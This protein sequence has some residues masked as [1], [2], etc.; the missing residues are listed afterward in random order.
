MGAACGRLM[1]FRHQNNQSASAAN[2]AAPRRDASERATMSDI[3]DSTC[4]ASA[5]EAA[6]EQ[7]APAAELSTPA[8]PFENFSVAEPENA[9]PRATLETLPEAIAAAC[10]RG[11]DVPHARAVPGPALSAGRPRHHGAV[12]YRQRQD[13][14]L[15]A[16]P[17]AASGSRAACR[18][19]PRSWC[20]PASW[21]C[22]WSTRRAP[23]SKAR[24]SVPWPSMAAWATK[25]RWTPCVTGPS[26][27]WARPA[28][29]W[30][31]C[32]AAPSRWTIWMPWSSTRPTACCPSA[33][34]PT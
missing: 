24:A 34:T 11:L 30:T 1:R 28:A 9:L 8:L 2:G 22:R 15:P 27:W 25:S 26:W 3:T 4:P 10:G 29:C 13:G 17:G 5:G 14:L 23:C 32:C 20:P 6:Q 16:A 19:G 18:P 21:P 33:S 12:P 31:I 7:A